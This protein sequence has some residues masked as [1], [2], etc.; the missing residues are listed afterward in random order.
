MAKRG[1]PTKYNQKLALEI[2]EA[3]STE[4]LGL[5]RLSEKYPH[6]PVK[7]QIF[8]WILKYPAFRDLYRLAKQNQEHYMAEDILDIAYTPEYIEDIDTEIKEDG[9]VIKKHKIFDNVHRSKLKIDA[10]KWKL[11]RLNPQKWGDTSK[12]IGDA[13]APITIAVKHLNVDDI[14]E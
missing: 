11:A 5:N 13:N 1:R 14:K 10:L 3:I 9:T 4:G 6:F 8:K 7:A 12:I 2:C